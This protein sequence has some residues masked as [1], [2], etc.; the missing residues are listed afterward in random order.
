MTITIP[1][2]PRVLHSNARPHWAAKAR[3]T[4][5]YRGD[6][7]L[8]A[9]DAINRQ[10]PRGLPWTSATVKAVF[11][12]RVKRR[13]DLD[14]AGASLK[15]AMDGLQDAGLIA[16]DSGLVPLPP[17][18]LIDKSSPRVELIIETLGEGDNHG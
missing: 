2:P 7:Y 10:K 14:G 6:C 17:E 3:A 15:A 12:H 16:N 5:K 4:K 13:R 9:I 11:Y 18:L 1:L 8:A